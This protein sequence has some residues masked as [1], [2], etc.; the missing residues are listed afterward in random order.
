MCGKSIVWS[1]LHGQKNRV[2][3]VV[4]EALLF[5]LHSGPS[6]RPAS[7]YAMGAQAQIQMTEVRLSRRLLDLTETPRTGQ[8]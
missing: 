4:V 2:I 5:G 7:P 1:R 8:S 6:G 3:I